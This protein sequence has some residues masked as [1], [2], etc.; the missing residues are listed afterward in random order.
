MKTLS[1]SF[2]INKFLKFTKKMEILLFRISHNCIFSLFFF[3]FLLSAYKAAD[4]WLKYNDSHYVLRY[5]VVLL[6]IS[7]HDALYRDSII[8]FRITEYT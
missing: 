5:D 7:D 4:L 6:S 8:W 1:H 2:L 3:F